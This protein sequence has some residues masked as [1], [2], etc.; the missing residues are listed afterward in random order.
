MINP[1]LKMELDVL[2]KDEFFAEKY[3]NIYIFLEKTKRSIDS[4]TKHIE[5]NTK[6]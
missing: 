3:P 1:M 2:M 5:L 4:L 6:R